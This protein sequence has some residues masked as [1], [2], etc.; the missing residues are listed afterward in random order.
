L[1]PSAIEPDE[2]TSIAALAMQFGD[3]GG[4]AASQTLS[5]SPASIDQE[6][7]ADL[8]DDTAKVLQRRAGHGSGLQNAPK[9]AVLQQDGAGAILDGPERSLRYAFG[10]RFNGGHTLL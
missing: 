2:T 9:L 5:T 10:S 4:Q 8:D 7:R 1:R 6:R 3:I